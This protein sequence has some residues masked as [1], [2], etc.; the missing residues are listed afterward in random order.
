MWIVQLLSEMK[1]KMIS[2]V[3]NATAVL[4]FMSDPLRQSLHRSDEFQS[5]RIQEMSRLVL[6]R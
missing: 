3:E 5:K 4:R 1:I 2:Q 6:L